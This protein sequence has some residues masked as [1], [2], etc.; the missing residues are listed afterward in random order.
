[1]EFPRRQQR[2][3]ARVYTLGFGIWVLGF[4]LWSTGCATA[5]AARVPDGPPLQVPAPPPRVL[6]P[7]EEGALTEPEAAPPAAA[8]P[9]PAGPTP[10]PRPQPAPPPPA[11]ASTPP[12]PA[13]PQP[14]GR[15]LRAAPSGANAASERNVRNILS[16]AARDIN[17]VDYLKLSPEGR[18]QYEQSK[19]F[20]LQAEEALKQRN[21][22]FAATL[23][24]K[25]AQIAAEL[26]NR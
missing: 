9:R 24:E 15:E 18:A 21:V 25:A 17:Q 11:A 22:V 7:V 1:M 12:A 10:S 19:R 5:R 16:R 20:S 14:D 23:A 3:L 26:L 4:G 8:A 2:V 13:P 6:G